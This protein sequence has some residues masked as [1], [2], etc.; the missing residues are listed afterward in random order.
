MGRESCASGLALP[1]VP[2][3]LPAAQGDSVVLAVRRRLRLAG[4]A[5]IILLE[6]DCTGHVPIWPYHCQ[7]AR[8]GAFLCLRILPPCPCLRSPP[9]PLFLH[10]LLPRAEGM[11]LCSAHPCLGQDQTQPHRAH[12]SQHTPVPSLVPQIRAGCL[13]QDFPIPSFLHLDRS[14]WSRLL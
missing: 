13:S 4:A 14:W 6:R 12:F 3:D 5:I 2:W 11:L 8:R 9:V 10:N 1:C 7:G